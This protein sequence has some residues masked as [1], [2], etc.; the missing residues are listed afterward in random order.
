MLS[1]RREHVLLLLQL[2]EDILA[3]FELLALWQAG[4]DLT[5]VEHMGLKI[6]LSCAAQDNFDVSCYH[7]LSYLP[8]FVSWKLT[9]T[10][11]TDYSRYGFI[12]REMT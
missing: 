2:V 12:C 3:M 7:T 10:K 8:L 1:C 11:F 9:E 5:E 4:C 6:L